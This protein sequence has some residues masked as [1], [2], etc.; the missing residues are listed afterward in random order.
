MALVHTGQPQMN[1]RMS[2]YPDEDSAGTR[3]ASKGKGMAPGDGV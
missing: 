3:V 1:S 2:L